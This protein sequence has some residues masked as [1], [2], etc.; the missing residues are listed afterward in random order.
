MATEST[1]VGAFYRAD[2][3]ADAVA[4]L[5]EH[6]AVL[7]A[8][9]QSLMP[10]LRQGMIDRNVIVDISGV[11]EHNEIAVDGED[12][13]VGGL[14]THR[15]VI[16]SNAVAGSWRA[17][18]ETA[19]AIGDPQVRNWGTVG[20]GVAHADPS[21]DY[22][23]TLIAMDATVEY[24]DGENTHSELVEDFYLGQYVTVL[25]DHEIVTGIRVPRPSAGSGV[26]FEKFA[27]RRGDMSL[28]NAAA[29]VTVEEGAITAARL[30][31]G[32]MAPVPL[33]L[34]ELEEMLEGTDAADET[35]R[36]EVAGR[37]S[38]YTD[39]VPESHASVSYKNRLAEN[40]TEKA[41]DRAVRRAMEDDP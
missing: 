17:L 20:G 23:P 32:A 38:E 31:V 15:E 18:S 2:T 36:G 30:C 39:P 12:L 35:R 11:T 19:K 29:R 26:A 22:P 16:E 34:V 33:R 3:I 8:G 40:L 21:L 13:V 28:V 41:L 4:L 9:G 6:D 1:D 5:R 24:T 37:V 7:I 25:D 10:L 14:A 27:W